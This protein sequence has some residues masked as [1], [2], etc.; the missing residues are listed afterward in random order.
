MSGEKKKERKKESRKQSHGEAAG[1][2]LFWSNVCPVCRR[3]K[4]KEHEGAF[5][6][7]TCA[8]GRMQEKI[9]HERTR[10]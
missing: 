7:G 8:L 6:Y 4:G 5:K 10:S 9:A 2:S 3:R 1:T